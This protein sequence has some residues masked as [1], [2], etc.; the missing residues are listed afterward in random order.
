MRI[1][2]FTSSS[3]D[4]PYFRIL[5]DGLAERGHRVLFGTLGDE[6][7]PAWLAAI[8]SAGHFSLGVKRR[9]AYPW[10]ALKLASVLGRN[11]VEVCHAHL[12]DAG[13]VGLAAGFVSGTPARVLMRHHLDDHQLRRKPVHVRLDRMMARAAHCTIV[14]S[15]AVQRHMTNHEGV[16]GTPIH[17]IH[18]G[19]DF[20]SLDSASG[21]REAIRAELGLESSFVIGFTGRLVP[22][23]G[24]GYLFEAAGRLNSEIPELRVLLVGEEPYPWLSDAAREHGVEDRIIQLGFRR[25]APSYMAATDVAVHPSLSDSFPQTVIETMAVGTPIV[26]SA[27]GGIPE[28]IRDGATGTLVPPRDADAIVDAILRSRGDVES[29]QRIAAAGQRLVRREFTAD[30]MVDRYLDVASGLLVGR[31]GRES[32]AAT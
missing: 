5:A 30:A 23:K 20:D 10:A 9:V 13:A 31:P 19:F 8:P 25:N 17:V 22:E 2:H 6:P 1:C 28:I 24:L 16:V 26:A 7:P 21:D 32:S 4:V 29:R 3:L 18:Y 12:F 27:V 14:P 11:R 15:A